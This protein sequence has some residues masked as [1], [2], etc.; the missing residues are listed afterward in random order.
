MKHHYFL[1]DKLQRGET[2]MIIFLEQPPSD[3]CSSAE[4]IVL[5]SLGEA[6]TEERNATLYHLES[7]P[8]FLLYPRLI[9]S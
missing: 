1:E 3:E 5:E 7:K 4:V 8:E 9:Q 2:S 6:V